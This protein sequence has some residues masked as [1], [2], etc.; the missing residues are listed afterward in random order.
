MAITA[1]RRSALTVAPI[2]LAAAALLTDHGITLP[3]LH[4]LAAAD[5]TS[6]GYA[7][8]GTFTMAAAIAWTR[9]RRTQQRSTP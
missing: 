9:R 2:L 8:I 3:I 4:Q 1:P 5:T 7:L 6:A